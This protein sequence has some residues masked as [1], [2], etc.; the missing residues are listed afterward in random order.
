MARRD[1][2][3]QYAYKAF[4]SYNHKDARWAEWL[5]QQI[6]AFRIPVDLVGAWAQSGPVPASLAPIFRD[7]TSLAAGSALDNGLRSTLD[8]SSAL[9]VICSP[10]SAK[11][12]YVN[13]EVAYF[14]QTGKGA[15]IFPIIVDGEPN[16]GG[17][18]E[19]FVP[20]L[21]YEVDPVTGELT[22][23]QTAPIAADA[24]PEGEGREEA[25]IKLIAG[26][27]GVEVGELREKHN[28]ILEEEKRRAEQRARRATRASIIA[29]ILT[30]AAAIAGGFAFLERQSALD[31]E[32][33]LVARYVQQAYGRGE[34]VQAAALLTEVLPTQIGAIIPRPE[35]PEAVELAADLLARRTLDQVVAGHEG[36][37]TDAA[38]SP[39]GALYAVAAEDGGVRIWRREDRTVLAE[40]AHETSVVSVRFSADGSRLLTAAAGGMVTLWNTS[41]AEAL[42][43]YPH[44]RPVRAAEF[45][46]DGDSLFTAG[47]DGVLRRWSVDGA[48][49]FESDLDAPLFAAGLD[50]TGQRLA[51]I[52]AQGVILVDAAT[53]RT[54]AQLRHRGLVRTARFNGDGSRLV[55]AD[56]AA[57][58][59]VFNARTGAVEGILD[60][61]AP[62]LSAAFDASGRRIVTSDADNVL[63]IWSGQG[64]SRLRVEEELFGHDAALLDA[65]FTPDGR[66]IVSR[67]RDGTARF[68]DAADGRSRAV[69][70]LNGLSESDFE[71]RTGHAADLSAGR[72]AISADGDRLMT[73]AGETGAAIWVLTALDR[74]V[75]LA[76][77][78]DGAFLAVGSGEGDITLWRM[79][80]RTPIRRLSGHEGGVLDLSFSAD[81]RRLVSGSSDLTVR[82]W[83]LDAL[84]AETEAGPEPAP[85]SGPETG[86]DSGRDSGPE[87]G[88]TPDEAA[89]GPDY[90]EAVD[91]SVIPTEGEM[92]EA[93]EAEAE[94]NAARADENAAQLDALEDRAGSQEEARDRLAALPVL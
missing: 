71:P 55:T 2:W 76:F 73:T 94:Q 23:K 78:P 88:S 57:A 11:S 5:E 38:I 91:P 75:S 15:R 63:R 52:A 68:W 46:A 69:F 4:I 13:D 64:A 36:A 24:R 87:T 35:T 41:T 47:M 32:T 82:L 81:S 93:A 92:V 90:D 33:E 16:S 28:S 65:L 18:K 77:S 26:V 85:E 34:E 42:A 89:G 12:T 84:A 86:P 62:P 39:D 29:S 1:P 3:G 80:T 72:I 27:L 10:D 83:D 48:V 59:R 6:E 14:K 21:R 50:P 53:G 67:S 60:S 25:L 9:I 61:E 30:L 56:G 44:E 31:R 37:A 51:V 8:Q 19:C 40:L 79:S 7:R 20:A 54:M 58:A 22:D 17:R 49:V 45:A 43:E 74:D 70:R 66:H